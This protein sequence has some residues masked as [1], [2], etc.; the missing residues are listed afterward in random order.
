M[1][2]SK[3][4]A[5]KKE[6]KKP[7]NNFIKLSESGD[8][9]KGIY[10][11][12]GKNKYG[13]YMEIKIGNSDKRLNLKSAVLHSLIKTNINSF[14]D[15]ENE[16]EVEIIRGEKAKGKEYIN[17]QVFIDGKELTGSQSGMSAKDIIEII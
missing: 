9:V 4:S 14:V 10:K 6:V 1:S 2:N 17:Y 3:K 13:L 7:E 15:K 8:S 12:F 16:L 11:G 5:A